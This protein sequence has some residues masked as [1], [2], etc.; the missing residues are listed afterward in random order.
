MLGIVFPLQVWNS[1][2]I[3]QF[4][5]QVSHRD[6]IASLVVGVVDAILVDGIQDI[7]CLMIHARLDALVG[8]QQATFLGLG[9]VAH[10]LGQ[11]DASTNV[12][13]GRVAHVGS[14]L[15]IQTAVQFIFCSV[16]VNVGTSGFIGADAV[17]ALLHI[18]VGQVDGFIEFAI[19]LLQIDG[20]S[21]CCNDER[22][23]GQECKNEVLFHQWLMIRI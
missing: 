18:L 6:V 23:E 8:Q 1:A 16:V 11:L 14:I 15:F 13:D 22:Q 12:V 4:L 7:T 19:L 9:A 21:R 20:G 10:P 5:I 17:F 2:I 3:A